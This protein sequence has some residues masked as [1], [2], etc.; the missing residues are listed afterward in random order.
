MKVLISLP[1][2][3]YG[4]M[5]AVIPQRHRSKLIAEILE[6][7][8]EKR[9]QELYEAALAVAKEQELNEE[10]ADWDV[11]ISDGIETETW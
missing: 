9:E 3:L 6:R 10:M 5:L 8:I 2:E 7:E 1:D 11:T 4:R